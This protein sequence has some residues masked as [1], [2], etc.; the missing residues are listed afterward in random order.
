MSKIKIGNYNLLK[1]KRFVDFGAYL[2]GGNR[3]NE[4]LIP[5][6]YLPADA[7]EG[8]ELEVFV[9]N[10]SEDR[11]IA[12]TERPK[13][14]VGEFAFLDVVAT[15]RI[16][17]F[18]DWGLMKD[19]LVPFGQQ[20]SRM[21]EGGRYLVYVYLDDA[22]KRIVASAKVEKFLGNVIPD[23]KAGQPVEILVTEKTDIGYACIVDNLHR[24]MVYSNQVFGDIEIGQKLNA[25]VGQVRSDGKIDVTLYDT[26]RNRTEELAD[27]ILE[28]IRQQ[29][30]GG[31]PLTDKSSPE[32]ITAAFRCSKRDFKQAVGHLL[33]ASKIAKDD[34]GKLLL[35]R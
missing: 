14:V 11:L 32:E 9:Y 24:G 17:A 31:F 20:K 33:K 10:D 7:A 27:R 34:S 1:I 4:I 30:D 26:A 13:A 12:T 5:T 15:N 8:D 29:P 18:L 28:A 23:Y 19:L 21:H 35:R 2:D 22:T 3:S 16:G 25:Y 6:R